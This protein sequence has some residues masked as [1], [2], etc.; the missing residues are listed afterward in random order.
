M[1]KLVF[2]PNNEG[3]VAMIRPDLREISAYQC[4]RKTAPKDAPFVIVNEQDI[5]FERRDYFDAWEIDFSNPDGY[6]IGVN[7]WFKEYSADSSIADPDLSPMT[8]E[9]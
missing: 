8:S 1:T 9:E 4:G 7:E 3:G 2:Y 6:G 5:P